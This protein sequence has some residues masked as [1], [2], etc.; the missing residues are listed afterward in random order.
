MNGIYINEFNKNYKIHNHSLIW[1]DCK[2]NL[3]KDLIYNYL[4]KYK[5][6]SYNIDKYKNNGNYIFYINKCK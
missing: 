2:F 6:G 4:N 1:F 5:I 3:G